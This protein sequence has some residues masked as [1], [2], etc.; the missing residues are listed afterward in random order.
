MCAGAII[1]S[2]ISTLVYGTKDEAMGCCCSVID[3]FSE[4]LGHRPQVYALVKE[5]ECRELLKK[6]F[7]ELR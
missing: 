2:R 5:Q 4:N 6:F 3:L 1:Q 7:E